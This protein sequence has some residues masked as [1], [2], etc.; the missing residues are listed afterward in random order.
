MI[1]LKDKPNHKELNA[2]INGVKN[3]T[4]DPVEYIK[5]PAHFEYL[6][7]LAVH[8]ICVN[9]LVKL[10]DDDIIYTLVLNHHA[11]QY[12]DQWKN[13]PAYNVRYTL[14]LQGYY[15]E[16]F[17]HDPD[18][19]IRG[20]VT[21]NN[22]HFIPQVINEPQMLDDI[23]IAVN[24]WKEL[25]PEIGQLVYDKAKEAGEED[26]EGLELKLK[27]MLHQPSI[28]EKTMSRRQLYI[29]GSPLWARN[30]TAGQLQWLLKARINNKEPYGEQILKRL[31]IEPTDP[32]WY[33]KMLA[34]VI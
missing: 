10:N 17:I 32:K 14:A 23:I 6:N 9:E 11:E 34:S 27:A 19:E 5:L 1:N 31:D 28:I 13:H 25:E 21:I 26:L 8:G 15:P 7:E 12:Y 29:S 3:G 2:F 18:Y 30:Y 33:N 22:P 24:Q 16:H 4:I 20:N